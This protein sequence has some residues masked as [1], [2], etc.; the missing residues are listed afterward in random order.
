MSD[1]AGRPKVSEPDVAPEEKE[2]I[3]RFGKRD[4]RAVVFSEQRG[5]VGRLLRHPEAEAESIILDD[6]ST[7]EDTEELGPNDTVVAYHGT[8]PIGALK[9]RLS[10]RDTASAARVISDGGDE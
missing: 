10:A 5:P 1:T 8:V 4:E 6:G 3:F 7:V 9:V 2:T